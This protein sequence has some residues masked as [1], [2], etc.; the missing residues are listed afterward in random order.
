MDS[1]ARDSGGVGRLAAVACAG[2]ITGVVAMVLGCL[3]VAGY[4]MCRRGARGRR[5]RRFA[6]DD[7]DAQTELMPVSFEVD[8]S[9]QMLLAIDIDRCKSFTAVRQALCLAY[10]DVSGEQL[11]PSSMLIEYEDEAN[12]FCFCRLESNGPIVDGRLRSARS[13]H[14]TA[15]GAGKAKGRA[16]INMR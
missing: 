8:G 12:G 5:G 6:D 3:I 9:P 16:A 15:S 2:G 11:L 1:K 13:L 14:V 7:E 10:A 4:A